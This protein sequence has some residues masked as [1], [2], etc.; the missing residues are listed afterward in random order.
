M[1]GYAIYGRE[2]IASMVPPAQR[3]TVAVWTEAVIAGGTTIPYEACVFRSTLYRVSKQ[4]RFE[5]EN[6]LTRSHDGS[7]N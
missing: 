5:L 3:C 7:R 6:I 4:K 1:A 2:S